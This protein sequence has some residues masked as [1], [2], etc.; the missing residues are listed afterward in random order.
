MINHF[1]QNHINNHPN[2][3]Q[4]SQYNLITSPIIL[5]EI[6]ISFSLI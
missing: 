2:P 6:I 5:K 4:Y 1:I 3:Y